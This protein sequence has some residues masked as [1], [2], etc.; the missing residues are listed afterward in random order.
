MRCFRN[1]ALWLVILA[2]SGIWL[3]LT[4]KKGLIEP[5][6]WLFGLAALL[7]AIFLFCRLNNHTKTKTS[8]AKRRGERLQA[9]VQLVVFFVGQSLFGGIDVA[10]RAFS[11]VP[12]KP[13]YIEFTLTLQGSA[14]RSLFI[15]LV[16]LMPGTVTVAV[17]GDQLK[18]H[19]LDQAMSVLPALMRLQAL[20]DGVFSD[21]GDA[22]GQGAS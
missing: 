20:L 8:K 21:S 5:T 13:D 15:A 1:P 18:I 4:G 14:A 6:G 7:P 22:D 3:V 2:M 17:N 11:R 16:G 10:R 19:R 9:L 12:V